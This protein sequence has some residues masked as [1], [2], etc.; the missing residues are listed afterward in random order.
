[1]LISRDLSDTDY[2]TYVGMSRDNE[3]FLVSQ[4]SIKDAV[5]FGAQLSVTERAWLMGTGT[6]VGSTQPRED[7]AYTT[8]S[9]K[10]SVSGEVR[11]GEE[12]SIFNHVRLGEAK[13]IQD[14]SYDDGTPLSEPI[15]LKR[16]Y[17]TLN[18]NDALKKYWSCL[19]LTQI[20]YFGN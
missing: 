16:N 1:L 9:N 8:V 7:P 11:F 18:R 20:G 3:I 15:Y 19:S 4:V 10:F 13:S 2:K 6:S 12:L 5:A 17:N 14:R